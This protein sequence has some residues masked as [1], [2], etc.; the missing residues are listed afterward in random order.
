METAEDIL[1]GYATRA[2]LA[3]AFVCSERTIARYE[4]EPD[5]LPNL[6]LGGR[7]LYPLDEAKQWVERRLRSANPRRATARSRKPKAAAELRADRLQAQERDP[8]PASSRRPKPKPAAEI[9][10]T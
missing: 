7:K 4:N 10:V 9:R 1:R 8:K 3:E 5:G 2:E 6:M